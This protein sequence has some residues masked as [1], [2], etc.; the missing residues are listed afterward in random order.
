MK[1]ATI[2]PGWNFWIDCPFTW[3]TFSNG[4]TSFGTFAS[5]YRTVCKFYD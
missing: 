5:S 2:V 3:L 4:S 1:C